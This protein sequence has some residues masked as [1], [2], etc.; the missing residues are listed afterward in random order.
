MAAVFET[1]DTGSGLVIGLEKLGG[2]LL[3]V[4]IGL[5]AILAVVGVECNLNVEGLTRVSAVLTEGDAVGLR[6]V[7]RSTTG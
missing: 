3:E 1:T 7:V 4:A 2:G 6:P 5:A